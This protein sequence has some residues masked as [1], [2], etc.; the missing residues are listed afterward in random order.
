MFETILMTVKLAWQNR[1][2]S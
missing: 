2:W 1:R